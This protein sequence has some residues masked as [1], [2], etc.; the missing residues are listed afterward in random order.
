MLTKSQMV[1]STSRMRVAPLKTG[2]SQATALRQAAR[3][4]RARPARGG[5]GCAARVRTVLSACTALLL[6]A[7]GKPVGTPCEI[8]GSGFTASHDCA[9]KCLSRWRVACPDGESVLP[10]VCAGEANCAPGAC[11]D[12]QLCYHFDDPFETRSYCVPDS[13]CGAPLTGAAGAEWEALA[14]ERAA[15]SRAQSDERRRRREQ[16]LRDGQ[17]AT[18]TE[19]A[20]LNDD[21]GGQ[22]SAR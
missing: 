3:W 5:R 11:P 20:P 9:T 16:A 10:K 19:A 12:G 4:Y 21:D 13:V 1:Y 22:E 14:Y 6:V 17:P 15:A 18:A 7:C 2:R 8:V